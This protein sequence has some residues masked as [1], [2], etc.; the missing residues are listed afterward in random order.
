M[1]TGLPY[2]LDP[3][4]RDIQ[5]EADPLRTLGPVMFE[6]LRNRS[7]V[8]DAKELMPYPTFIMNGDRELPV[9]LSGLAGQFGV[10]NG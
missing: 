2:A 3:F 1:S 10:S 7:L 6:H 4:D 5:A 8:V 9:H